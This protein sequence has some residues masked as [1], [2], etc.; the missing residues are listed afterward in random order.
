MRNNRNISFA[1]LITLTVLFCFGI[2]AYSNSSIRSYSIE[3]SS[4]SNNG[5]NNFSSDIDS[6]DDDQ[7][8]HVIENSTFV[9]S[10][11][12]MPIPRHYFLVNKLFLSVWQPPKVS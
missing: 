12:Q 7:N 9:E 1:V 4:C 8:S 11:S 10:V 3:L 6:C 5:E 2:H